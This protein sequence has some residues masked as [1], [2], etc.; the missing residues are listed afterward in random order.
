[1]HSQTQA[2][3]NKKKPITLRDATISPYRGVTPNLSTK[4]TYASRSRTFRRL[5]HSARSSLALVVPSSW[6][7][8]EPRHRRTPEARPGVRVFCAHLCQ[9]SLRWRTF[10]AVRVAFECGS[11]NCRRAVVFVVVVVFGFVVC[12]FFYSLTVSGV[13][14]CVIREFLANIA[15]VCGSC[16]RSTRLVSIDSLRVAGEGSAGR[17]FVFVVLLSFTLVAKV[18]SKSM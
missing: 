17:T 14:Y 9:R 12:F 10:S 16:H 11:N 4:L 8:P 3:T 13:F 7:P 18:P 2:T 15:C 5:R 1:M 6:L